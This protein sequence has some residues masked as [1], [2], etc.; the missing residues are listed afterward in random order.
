MNRIF[1]FV[2]MVFVATPVLSQEAAERPAEAPILSADTINLNDF[3]WI[4]RLLVVFADTPSDPRYIEQMATLSAR[5]DVLGERDVVIIT[6]TDPSARTEVRRT[7]RPRGFTLVLIGKDGA[8]NQRRPAPWGIREI[9]H[10]I[11]RLPLRRQELRER[12]GAR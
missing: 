12:S 7:L 2:F 8:I 3:L 4:S 10:S 9:A 6:D 11:D 5:L 1:S